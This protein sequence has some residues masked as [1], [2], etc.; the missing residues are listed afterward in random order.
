MI[1]NDGSWTDS[2]DILVDGGSNGRTVFRAL[3]SLVDRMTRL[4][5]NSSHSTHKWEPL[6]FA[7]EDSDFSKPVPPPTC[8]VCKMMLFGTLFSGYQCHDCSKFYHEKC[9][10]YG[11]PDKY[12]TE[13]LG[14]KLTSTQTNMVEWL[15]FDPNFIQLSAL[16]EKKFGF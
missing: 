11:T 9:F 1:N 4:P 12:I 16:M 5:L 10:L 15:G 8:D 14:E 7:T 13:G 6:I 2:F 3:Q